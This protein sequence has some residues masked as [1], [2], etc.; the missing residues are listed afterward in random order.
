MQP[1]N[2]LMVSTSYPADLSDWRGIFVRHLADAIARRCDLRLSLWAPPGEVHP[3]AIRACTAHEDAWLA[4][5]TRRGGIAHLLRTQKLRGL[6]ASVTLLR[7][8]RRVY[9]RQ[10]PDVYHVNWL[11]N[12]L[13]LPNNQRPALITVLGTDMQLLK[14][15][16][17]TTLVRCACRGR[18]VAIC[19][20]ADWMAPIL[21]SAFA[22][23]ALVR[24]VLFGIDPGWFS[25][26]RV[27]DH[28]PT[29]NWLVVARLTRDKLG[30][31]FEW[32]APFFI[33]GERKLHLFGPM[34]ESIDVPPWVNYHGPAAPADLREEWFPRAH[35]LI[36]L[37]RHSEGRPQVMLEAMA[38]GLPILASRLPAH[39]NLL[40]H[41]VTG[42]LVDSSTDVGAGLAHLEFVQNNTLIGAA[43]RRHVRTAVGTW[44]DCAARF[45]DLY[46]QL[47]RM[48]QQR[49]KLDPMQ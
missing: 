25:L 19:P 23:V 18:R 2:V 35:G 32:C 37:S 5:L 8:L 49:S 45:N 36:S 28:E 26:S 39:E 33:S 38:S 16:M 6:S 20:N 44:D 30:P 17:V 31:L 3:R 12:A 42:W 15:P 48:G 24:T 40:E 14:L 34:Q 9:R 22:D 46:Q 7:S 21:R 11:Q 29:P 43:A 10:V 41:G 27:F 1:L 13:P 4:D 47:F